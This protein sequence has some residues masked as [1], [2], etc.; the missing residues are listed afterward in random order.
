MNAMDD[1]KDKDVKIPIDGC[2]CTVCNEHE[3]K[4]QAK[5]IIDTV[6]SDEDAAVDK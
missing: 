5:K 2:S 1:H 3:E 6:K 4:F